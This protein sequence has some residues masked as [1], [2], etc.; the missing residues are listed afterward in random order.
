MVAFRDG[1]LAMGEGMEPVPA[2]GPSIRE[3]AA[4][5]N[6]GDGK[7][8]QMLENFNSH[9]ASMTGDALA[10]QVSATITDARQDN[11]AFPVTVNSTV[12]QTVQQATQAP[13]AAARATSDAVGKAAVPQK[14]RIEAEPSF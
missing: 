3:R 10:Q 6:R 8:Q 5:A 1:M 7:L 14:A 11:R 13:A 9:L 4:E 12:N 2:G